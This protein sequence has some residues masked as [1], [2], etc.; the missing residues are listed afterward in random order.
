MRFIFEEGGCCGGRGRDNGCCMASGNGEAEKS[1]NEDTDV[2][3]FLDEPF[4]S[5]VNVSYH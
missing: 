1:L 4:L 3:N 2:S 5:T